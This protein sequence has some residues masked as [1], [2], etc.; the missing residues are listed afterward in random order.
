MDLERV[1]VLM[2]A[3]IKNKLVSYCKNNGHT[4][5]YIVNKLVIDFLKGVKDGN[6]RQPKAKTASM[7]ARV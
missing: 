7:G 5:A 6:K 1:V 3:S 4:T 2:E